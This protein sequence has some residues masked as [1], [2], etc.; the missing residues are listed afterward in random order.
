M[1]RL[2]RR[3]FA[4]RRSLDGVLSVSQSGSSEFRLTLSPSALATLD[5][6]VSFADLPELDAQL[7]QGRPFGMLESRSGREVL[8]LAAPL[9]GLV[10]RRN[11]ALLASNPLPAQPR[12]AQLKELWL[13]DVAGDAEEFLSLDEDSS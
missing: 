9:S 1:L 5:G 13:L 10:L 8:Q 6:D 12:G 11:E 2:L 4:T 3:S 7:V